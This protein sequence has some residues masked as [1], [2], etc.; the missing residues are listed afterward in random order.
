MPSSYPPAPQASITR[1]EFETLAGDYWQR[2][3]APLERILKRNNLTAADLDA[4]ELLGGGTRV[5]KLQAVLS[6]TLGGRGLDRC[7]RRG[8]PSSA[9]SLKHA[10]Q[11][12]V[13]TG[14]AMQICNAP[15]VMP[16]LL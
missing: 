14:G 1:E 4:V 13:W 8:E 15:S 9:V 2:A 16:G 5:P 3:A 6:E 12:C 7:V 10:L 11:G